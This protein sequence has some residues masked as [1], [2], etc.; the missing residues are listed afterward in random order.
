MTMGYP[1]SAI[2][3]SSGAYALAETPE[4]QK[5]ISPTTPPEAAGRNSKVIGPSAT[6][7]ALPLRIRSPS[8]PWVRMELVSH[9]VDVTAQI[10]NASRIHRRIPPLR[11]YA[12][13]V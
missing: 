11:R 2:G 1:A 13:T 8:T 3:R 6:E 7:T 9:N 4:P 5:K 10:R 12:V